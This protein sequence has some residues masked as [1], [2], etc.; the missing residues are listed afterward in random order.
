MRE[1][2]IKGMLNL[3]RDKN[4]GTYVDYISMGRRVTPPVTTICPEGC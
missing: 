2:T 1:S 3:A 4:G